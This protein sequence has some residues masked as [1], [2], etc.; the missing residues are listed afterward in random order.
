MSSKNY[1][2]SIQSI[3]DEDYG[4]DDLEMVVKDYQTSSRMIEYYTVKNEQVLQDQKELT[5]AIARVRA[6]IRRNEE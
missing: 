1:D 2:T 4:C 6:S 3:L 5:K